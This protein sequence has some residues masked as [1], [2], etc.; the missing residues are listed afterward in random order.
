MK[1]FKCEKH[2]NY[3]YIHFCPICKIKEERDK[4]EAFI[5]A[6]SE[7]NGYGECVGADIVDMARK[8]LGKD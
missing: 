6:V 1:P 2:Q 8:L 3:K 7:M 5:E 4:Y